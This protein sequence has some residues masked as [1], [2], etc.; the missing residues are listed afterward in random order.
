MAGSRNH[1]NPTFVW[2]AI[3]IVLP[4][5]VLSAFGAVFLYQ[6]RALT[7]REAGD[8]AQTI[9]DEL[10]SQMWKQLT[11]TNADPEGQFGFEVDESGKL[12]Y[13][14]AFTLAPMPHPFNPAALNS[15]QLEL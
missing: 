6:D 7:L 12:I 8:R 13:P 1:R 11:A 9:A 10:A 14:P 2:Q 15:R 3:L 5:L 4:I